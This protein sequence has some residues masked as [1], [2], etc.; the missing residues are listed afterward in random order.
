MRQGENLCFDLDTTTPTFTNFNVANT[1]DADLFFNWAEFNNE[2]KQ[3]LYLRPEEDHGIGGIN[4]AV[5]TVVPLN[6]L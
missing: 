6:S 4:P 1:F 5:A 3:R 2:D